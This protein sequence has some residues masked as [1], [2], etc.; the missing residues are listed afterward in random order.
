MYH[1]LYAIYI[2]DIVSQP[3]SQGLFVTWPNFPNAARKIFQPY[4]KIWSCDN[5]SLPGPST[6]RSATEALG[7]SLIVS[8][9]KTVYTWYKNSFNGISK[10]RAASFSFSALAF[11]NLR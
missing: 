6:S 4:W 11:F 8:L 2:H 1:N 7:T 10:V 9:Y 3:R 5:Q